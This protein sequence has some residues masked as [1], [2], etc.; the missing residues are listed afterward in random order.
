MKIAK[1]EVE[2]IMN[3][4]VSSDTDNGYLAFKAIEA[5]DFDS[6]ETLGY[7][8]YFYKFCKYNMSEWEEHAPKAHEILQRVFKAYNLE[9]APIT[10]SRALQL[11]VE[12]N[13][14]V[15]SIELFLERH[16]KDLTNSLSAL[17]YPTDKLELT[18]KLK[19]ND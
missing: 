12:H 14:S 6:K 11:M 18:I 1:T 15:D 8:I 9:S 19:R 10:Y 7:L 5:H 13:V 4:L 3:M 16:V 2:N 17:G